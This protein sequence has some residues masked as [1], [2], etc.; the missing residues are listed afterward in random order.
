MD[1]FNDECRKVGFDP[2]R[3]YPA[4]I[5]WDCGKAYGR[6]EPGVACW[7]NG[8]CGICGMICPVTEPRDFGHL[9]WP[10]N[11]TNDTQ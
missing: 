10:T 11:S 5:C 3:D 4:W 2:Y 8:E 7:H 6:R 9:N 1:R